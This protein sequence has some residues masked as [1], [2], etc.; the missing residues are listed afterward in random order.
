[1]RILTNFRFSSNGTR[2][3][4]TQNGRT[5]NPVM[6]QGG[7]RAR[8]ILPKPFIGKLSMSISPHYTVEDS[9]S[10]LKITTSTQRNWFRLILAGLGLTVEGLVSLFGW[11]IIALLL[12]LI[13][14]KDFDSIRPPL[15]WSIFI[16]LFIS[17]FGP[18][19]GQVG[20]E[21]ADGEI[22][23]VDNHEIKIHR[24]IFG[25]RQSRKHSAKSISAP[26]V[27]LAEHTQWNW[28]RFLSW[29]LSRDGP[30]VFYDRQKKVFVS[31]GKGLDESQ[32]KQIVA[33][34]QQCFPEYRPGYRVK[35]CFL[36]L[37]STDTKPLRVNGFV[38]S[39][40]L[41]V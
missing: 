39:I 6:K 17:Q 25:I 4:Y 28:K 31:F 23:E 16:L 9:G 35:I 24:E 12:T 8:G 18:K 33:L 26:N 41:S 2:I 1:M 14:P 20:W 19:I 13:L 27:P 11:F 10:S 36:N 38:A 34:I 37:V 22:I 7:Y 29:A 3:V 30:V 21:I 5:I 32:A 40:R 15:L